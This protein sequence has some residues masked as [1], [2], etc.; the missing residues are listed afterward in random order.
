MNARLAKEMLCDMN[1]KAAKQEP[2]LS[3]TVDQVYQAIRMLYEAGQKLEVINL[4]D[5]REIAEDMDTYGGEIGI[6][7]ASK[8]RRLIELEVGAGNLC[9]R[10]FGDMVWGYYK[11]VSYEAGGAVKFESEPTKFVCGECGYTD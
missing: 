9:P 3:C 8:L 6:M 2:N 4:S 5:L 1:R 11:P 7:L 10:C